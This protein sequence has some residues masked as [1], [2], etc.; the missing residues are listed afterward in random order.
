VELDND[1]DWEVI[2]M[3]LTQ[4]N[5]E[6]AMTMTSDQVRDLARKALGNGYDIDVPEQNPLLVGSDR[7][8]R[9]NVLNQLT[10]ETNPYHVVVQSDGDAGYSDDID[11]RDVK[12][13][14]NPFRAAIIVDD[15]QLA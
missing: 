8:Y 14:L 10:G 5:N 15:A 13:S 6:T 4:R 7:Y 3:L 11:L 1:T 12:F 9:I 2:K